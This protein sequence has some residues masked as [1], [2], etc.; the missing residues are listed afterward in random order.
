MLNVIMLMQSVMVP[1][2][3]TSIFDFRRLCS[4]H[5]VL[6]APSK[7]ITYSLYLQPNV[8]AITLVHQ[9]QQQQRQ[10]QPQQQQQLQQ[11][12]QLAV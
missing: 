4:S 1:L 11:P 8:N 2:L 6:T 3:E 5:Q 12:L 7:P 10:Q 9:L